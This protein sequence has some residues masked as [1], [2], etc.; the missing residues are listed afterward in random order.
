MRR[1]VLFVVSTSGTVHLKATRR[2]ATDAANGVDIIITTS[3]LVTVMTCTHR[4]LANHVPMSVS[5]SLP[6]HVGLRSACTTLSKFTEISI[7]TCKSSPVYIRHFT[8]QMSSH[9][10][11]ITVILWFVKMSFHMYLF[12]SR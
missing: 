1:H 6:S 10:E 11:T 4:F 2:H 12:K 8:D 9:K 5:L 7:W 3:V